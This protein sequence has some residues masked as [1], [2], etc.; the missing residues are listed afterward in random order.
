[1]YEILELV[2]NIETNKHSE[3]PFSLF[4]KT[5]KYGGI[6]LVTEVAGELKL[7]VTSYM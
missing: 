5:W 6:V 3:Q 7:R 1:M 4:I 2:L